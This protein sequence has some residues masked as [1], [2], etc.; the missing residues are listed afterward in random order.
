MQHVPNAISFASNFSF[1]VIICLLKLFCFR[2]Q[3][4][5]QIKPTTNIFD[6]KL[7]LISRSNQRPWEVYYWCM[8]TVAV[9]LK[10]K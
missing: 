3:K 4:R 1:R 5:K 8:Q 6:H 10:W 9:Q 2:L 7:L